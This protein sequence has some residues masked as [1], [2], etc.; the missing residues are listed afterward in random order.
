MTIGSYTPFE[1]L[2]G[3]E[4]MF[5]EVQTL[6]RTCS[7]SGYAERVVGRATDDYAIVD[8]ELRRKFIVVLTTEIPCRHVA[9]RRELW[10]RDLK[11]KGREHLFQNLVRFT[12]DERSSP[13]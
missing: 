6:C 5:G 7:T 3:E 11:Y 2:A 1:V 10:I 8:G 13:S 12:E 9:E 4:V